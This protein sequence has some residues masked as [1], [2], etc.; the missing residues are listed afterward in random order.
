VKA[1]LLYNDS[2]LD[3]QR[4]LPPG[5][6]ELAQDLEL[7]VLLRAMARGDEYLYDVARAALHA[8]L[9][10]T[11]QIA[12][13]QDVLA[14][15]MRHPDGAVALY[16][17]AVEAIQAERSIWG[18]LFSSASSVLHRSIQVME[19]FAGYL[20]DLRAIA[21]EQAGQFSSAGF[22]RL[23]DMLRSELDDAYLAEI[24]DHLGRLKFKNGL[25]ISA[26]LDPANKGAGYVLRRLPDGQPGLRGLLP[27]G[28]RPPGYVVVVAD[29]D[30]TGQ[31]TLS[32]LRDKGIDL[33][34][35]AMAQS[36]EH[37]RS[38]FDM[39]RREV[40]FYIGCLN[41]RRQLR[42]KGLPLCMPTALPAGKRALTAASLYDPCLA[43]TSADRVVGNDVQADGKALVMITGAN[44][45]GKSTF[46]RS[47]GLAQL[48][49]QSGMFVAAESFAANVSAGIYTHYKRAED[50]TMTS[51]KLDEELARMSEITDAIT[52]GGLLLC[53]ESFAST[54]EREGSHI[55][56]NIIQAMLDSG[57]SV[58]F[59]THFYDLARRL[60]ADERHDALFLRA[61]RQ[62]DGGRTYL[63]AEGEPLP[64][65]HARDVYE[66]V[67][68]A[69][70]E[71]DIRAQ[72]PDRPP[73][74]PRRHTA[75]TG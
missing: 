20:R 36:C 59:V 62:A 1:F 2:D 24:K 12:Y 9:P 39:L 48:M 10:T 4:P 43:L 68:G 8:S 37:I 32:S 57:V 60:Y 49:M 50:A 33:V 22:G 28:S 45:G 16:D 51:G 66:R 54:N 6:P 40:G 38:F 70:L 64:T 56:R 35:S 65:G 23:F 55:A 15:C 31:Q 61:D 27:V 26:R 3:M 74:P 71:P 47:I 19:I 5:E 13:R 67:F 17:V 34:A 53:N 72:Q 73:E 18:G 21:D 46:L 11:E 29:R 7:D 58:F 42:D 52:P 30:I 14:D 75:G 41:L 69:L 25:L 63:L 44:Q